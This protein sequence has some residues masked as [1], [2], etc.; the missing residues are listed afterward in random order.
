MCHD[1]DGFG[2]PFSEYPEKC[3]LVVF[4]ISPRRRVE[5]QEE[6]SASSP[7]FD[8]DEEGKLAWSTHIH[9]FP[10]PLK[11]W[12]CAEQKKNGYEWI[13]EVIHCETI[14]KETAVHFNKGK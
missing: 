1:E 14:S 13:W 4:R 10:G 3:S 9:V 12:M 6:H 2:I 5:R 11:E 8:H 7:H